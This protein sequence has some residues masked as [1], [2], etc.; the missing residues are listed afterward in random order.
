MDIKARRSIGGFGKE[1]GLKSP[2][3]TQGVVSGIIID[4]QTTR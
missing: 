3:E 1:N 4:S 2:K